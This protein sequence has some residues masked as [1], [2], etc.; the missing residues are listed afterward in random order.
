MTVSELV[1]GLADEGGLRVLAGETHVLGDRIPRRV[2]VLVRDRL[3]LLSPR[4]Q[5]LLQVAAALGRTLDPA[6][7]AELVGATAATV[8]PMLRE[9]VA[10]GVL[11]TRDRDVCFQCVLVL[12]VVRQTIPPAARPLGSLVGRHDRGPGERVDQVHLGPRRPVPERA[13]S[14]RASSWDS[15]SDTEVTIAC[16]VSGG[17]TNRQ[18]ATRIS[19]SPHTVNYYLRRMFRKL[20]VTSRVELA[21][22]A[23]TE[24]LAS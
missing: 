3:S 6:W 16:L 2:E 15:L 14:H 18:I 4:C 19:L 1:A 10:A 13:D 11:T 24:R 8:Q 17:L 5:H 7:I 23:S 20:N 22:L 9:A 21:S 12:R